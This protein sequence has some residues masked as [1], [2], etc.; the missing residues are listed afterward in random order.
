MGDP[1]MH[2]AILDLGDGV[3]LPLERLLYYGAL[4]QGASGSGKSWFLRLLYELV[5]PHVPCILIDPEGEFASLR[6]R[7][8]FV[9][10]G[11]DGEIP[12]SP[13]NAAQLARRLL[14]ARTSAVVDIYDLDPEARA[15]FVREFM[16]SL[17][18]APRSLWGPALVLLDEAHQF[19]PESSHGDS[20]ARRAVEKFAS[21]RR[22][23]GWG[24]VPAT[25][26]LSKLSK[27][28]ASDLGTIFIGRTNA[29]DVRRAADL[30]GVPGDERR[31]FTA[32]KDG[33]W[34]C[35]SAAFATADAIEFQAHKPQTRP[36]KPGRKYE[37]PAPANRIK[38]VAGEL[39]EL[40]AKPDDEPV[41]LDQALAR[42]AT[43]RRELAEAARG[44]AKSAPTASLKA[45]PPV[46]DKAAI[47]AGVAAAVAEMGAWFAQQSA[48]ARQV[49]DTAAATAA[50]LTAQMRD[51][52]KAME[53][54]PPRI[55]KAKIAEG[56]KAAGAA[57]VDTAG[58]VNKNIGLAVNRQQNNGVA[59]TVRG[60]MQRE[61]RD[62]VALDGQTFSEADFQNLP[63]G[64][65]ATLIVCAQY[66]PNATRKQIGALTGYT[67]RTR[68]QYLQNLRTKGLIEPN[69][70]AF[71]ATDAGLATLGDSYEPLP[72]GAALLTHWLQ[73]LPTGEE[74]VL[75]FVA[76]C[77]PQ[78]IDRESISHATGYTRRT[79]DQYI[80]NLRTRLLVENAG[81][82]D[83][84][85]SALLFDDGGAR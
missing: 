72:T 76:Q 25:Q 71:A 27:D 19:S 78:A 84:I 41:T 61:A 45:A 83:V 32:L 56:V 68:D 74:R 50:H 47:E 24:F 16:A 22:K 18:A 51:A 17:C 34:L 38:S 3:A 81:G 65:R 80:Q 73:R 9:L 46:V 15:V 60:A 21:L 44:A 37:P 69:G 85:A 79:R 28:A 39:Q 23:R 58:L 5:C 53:N 36:P 20:V 4:V 10:V 35:T 43:L 54:R 64:E 26:R 29:I 63:K 75:K 40:A 12:A 48:T 42:I 11:T 30:L 6:E 70:D 55:T 31:R 2:H 13:K 33:K 59:A 14:E 62:L 1:N 8:D 57:A 49:F 52:A 67:R 82:G 66:S 7:C 77:Y